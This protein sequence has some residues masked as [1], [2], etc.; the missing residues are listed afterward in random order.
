MLKL[1]NRNWKFGLMLLYCQRLVEWL[2]TRLIPFVNL[3]HPCLC[4]PLS[5]SRTLQ[6]GARR[7]LSQISTF[8]FQVSSREWL[9]I[10]KMFTIF[11]HSSRYRTYLPFG[12]RLFLFFCIMV[13]MVSSGC[14]GVNDTAGKYVA[15]VDGEGISLNDFNRILKRDM[16]VMGGAM[17]LKKDEANRLR[18]EILNKLINEK[19]MLLRAQ[20]LSLSVNDEELCQGIE[21]IKKDYPDGG[22]DKVFTGGKLDYD[23]WKEELRKR[24]ILEKLIQRDVNSVI[25]VTENEALE[26]YQNHSEKYISGERVHVVQIVVRNRKE[27]EDILERLKSGGNF[28]KVAKEVSTGPEGV[29]GGDL[30]VFCRGIMPE[31]F[32]NVVFSLPPGKI[33]NVVKTTYGYHIFKVLK[34][35]GAKKISFSEAKNGIISELYKEKGRCEYMR[36]LKKLRS[37]AVIEINRDLLMKAD[38]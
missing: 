18:E 11:S 26:Y 4:V 5:A 8:Q 7:H 31:S 12:S 35:D 13:F 15:T 32:D 21:E 19:I 30:G 2:T 10:F 28:A 3:L 1:E 14:Q 27:A 24:L 34:K 9:H 20:K 33:S 16:D 17:P 38:T 23:I 22:F 29:R 37:E 6:A 36:W 25:T